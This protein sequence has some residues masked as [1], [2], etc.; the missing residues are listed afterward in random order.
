[1]GLRYRVSV[2]QIDR[3]RRCNRSWFLRY[4]LKLSEGPEG[5]WLADGRRWHK[6][7]EDYL[8]LGTI[9]PSPQSLTVLPFISEPPLPAGLVETQIKDDLVVGYMDYVDFDELGRTRLND[10][11]FGGNWKRLNGYKKD[12]ESAKRDIG[13]LVYTVS[14]TGSD[15]PSV[16]RWLFVH[17]RQLKCVPF[18]V[19]YETGE[20]LALADE[21]GLVD[22]IIK[23][24]EVSDMSRPSVVPDGCPEGCGAFGGCSYRAYCL[25]WGTPSYGPLSGFAKEAKLP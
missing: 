17:K 18:S 25:A 19:E 15:E 23:M 7:L 24:Q 2:S 4:I 1:L 11:K 16:F 9:P 6:E 13:A 21:I 14:Y 3:F 22:T 8:V 12:P 5:P 10:Y 20:A